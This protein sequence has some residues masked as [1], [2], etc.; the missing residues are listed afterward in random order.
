MAF[1]PGMGTVILETEAVPLGTGHA[2]LQ[3]Q[4]LVMGRRAW[5]LGERSVLAPELSIYWDR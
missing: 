2:Q 1:S 3:R 5:R 4:E